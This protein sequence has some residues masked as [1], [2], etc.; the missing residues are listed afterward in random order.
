[1]QSHYAEQRNHVQH[2]QMFSLILVAKEKVSPEGAV[3][4]D[5][6]KV[7][8]DHFSDTKLLIGFRLLHRRVSSGVLDWWED[9]ETDLNSG[10]SKLRSCEK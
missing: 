9:E 10:P 1:M 4:P 8:E 7:G 2:P 5:S 3:E 6:Q